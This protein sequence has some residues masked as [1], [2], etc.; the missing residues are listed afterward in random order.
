MNGRK[1][2][3]FSVLLSS[4]NCCVIKHYT[5]ITETYCKV[6]AYS[7]VNKKYGLCITQSDVLDV[8]GLD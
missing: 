6:V 4:G 3:V 7:L 1:Y 2:R 8:I 5:A